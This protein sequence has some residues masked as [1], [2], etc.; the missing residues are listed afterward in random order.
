VV[1]ANVSGLLTGSLEGAAQVSRGVAGLRVLVARVRR[2]SVCPGSLVSV[3]GLS[4]RRRV[5]GEYSLGSA[6]VVGN[7]C[8]SGRSD[9]SR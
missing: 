4:R 9:T 1:S 6:Q 7:Y 2:S 3:V 8:W 5:K